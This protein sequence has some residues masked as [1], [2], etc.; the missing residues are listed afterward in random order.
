MNLY[1]TRQIKKLVLT[2]TENWMLNNGKLMYFPKTTGAITYE[3]VICSHYTCAKSFNSV[4]STPY[5]TAIT[6]ASVYFN[7]GSTDVAAWKT[8]LAQQYADGTPV[9]VWYILETPTAEIITLPSNPPSSIK[10]Y[11]TQSTTPTPTNRTAK[12]VNG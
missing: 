2:G 6:D 4:F 1:C 12:V 9:I 11:L 5:S 8:Y 3:S 10:G 7:S